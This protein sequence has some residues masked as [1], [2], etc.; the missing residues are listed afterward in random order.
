MCNCAFGPRCESNRC[1]E[2]DDQSVGIRDCR[3]GAI[4]KRAQWSVPL[5]RRSGI[6]LTFMCDDC[7]QT[8]WEAL[9]TPLAGIDKPAN[10][11]EF[12]KP[13]ISDHIRLTAIANSR[14]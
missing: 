7:W 8:F 14:R 1:C 5:L 2:D 10:A 6:R 4:K 9:H 11:G 12:W 13:S 3:T